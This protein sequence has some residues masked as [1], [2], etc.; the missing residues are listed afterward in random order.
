VEVKFV[1][2]ISGTNCERIKAAVR[3][4]TQKFVQWR[5]A[6]T[7]KNITEQ[8]DEYWMQNSSRTNWEDKRS[9]LVTHKPIQWRYAQTMKHRM[10]KILDAK[11]I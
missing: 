10:G 6:Q 3:S 9:E 4:E 11:L 5:Y 8:E 2:R 1:Q 7:M